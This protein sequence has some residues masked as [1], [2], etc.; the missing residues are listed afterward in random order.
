MR[1]SRPP[2][3]TNST[4]DSA[5]NLGSVDNN[6]AQTSSANDEFVRIQSKLDN[7][8]PRQKM[9]Q[10]ESDI[11]NAETQNPDDYRFTYQRAKLEAVKNR[12]RRET[13]KALS[14]AGEKAIKA[15]K[16][17]DLLSDLQKDKDLDLKRLKGRKEWTVLE[18]ALRNK[19][20]KA[21]VEIG[22]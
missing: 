6:P 13:F 20:S 3:E 22:H 19:D 2:S 21:L 1:E 12:S 11:K 8:V 17:V 4:A 18:T 16:S 10:F 5:S 14:E 7:A 9:T 15:D